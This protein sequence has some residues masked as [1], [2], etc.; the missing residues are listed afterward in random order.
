MRHSYFSLV[1]CSR[2]DFAPDGK[3]LGSCSFDG[4]VRLWDVSKGE[5]IKI[6]KGHSGGVELPYSRRMERRC[7]PRVATP[8]PSQCYGTL[9]PAQCKIKRHW[10]RA[11]CSML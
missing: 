10:E 3:S 7:F 2:V 9:P 11:P 1:A 4:T 5:R 8:I 6:L